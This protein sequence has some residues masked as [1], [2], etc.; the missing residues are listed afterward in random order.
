MI[1]KLPNMTECLHNLLCVK[2]NQMALAFCNRKEMICRYQEPVASRQLC[3]LRNLVGDPF[4]PR[5]PCCPP[6]KLSLPSDLEPV[7]GDVPSCRV[8]FPYRKPFETGSQ[9][10]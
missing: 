9:V 10:R 4:V 1:G 2:S 5:G 3:W 6:E 7:L 8:T